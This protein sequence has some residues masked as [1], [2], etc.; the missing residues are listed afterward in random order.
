MQRPEVKEFVEFML[1]KGA[2]LVSE[3]GYLPLPGKAY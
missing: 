3:V 2:A 1:T